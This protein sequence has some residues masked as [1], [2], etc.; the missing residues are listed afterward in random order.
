MGGL[1]VSLKVAPEDY[2]VY[3]VSTNDDT[4]AYIVYPSILTFYPDNYNVPQ[5]IVVQGRNYE[6]T[7]GDIEYN[8]L[9]S[10]LET[11]DPHY[12]NFPQITLMSLTNFE[13]PWLTVTTPDC[14]AGREVDEEGTVCDIHVS[15]KFEPAANVTVT[16]SMADLDEATFVGVAGTSTTLVFSPTDYAD[17][18]I[19]TV[20]GVDDTVPQVM[21]ML[22]L[23]S[24][25]RS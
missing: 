10:L 21:R 7:S 2:V 9:L 1:F 3:S 14:V 16:V 13:A 5:P 23:W 8:V 22:L 11:R 17:A 25:R 15:L 18:H 19:V 4:Q 20:K 12:S 24:I 6:A